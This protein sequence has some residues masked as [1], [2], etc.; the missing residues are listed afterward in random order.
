MILAV[1]DVA[2]GTKS[3]GG[4]STLPMPTFTGSMLVRFR[5]T[6]DPDAAQGTN[7]SFIS[8]AVHEI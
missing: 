5:V 2:S 7:A 3:V 6:F 4:Q 8:I 1:N